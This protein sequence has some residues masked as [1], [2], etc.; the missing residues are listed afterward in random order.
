M[1]AAREERDALKW[2]GGNPIVAHP[3]CRLFS[4]LS[5]FSTAPESE[6]QLAYWSVGKVR[7]WGGVLE[8]PAHSRLWKDVKLPI[9][10]S[11]DEWGFTLAVP[12]FWFGHSAEKDTWLYICGCERKSLPEIP[13]RMG[14]PSD[15]F[16]GGL[17]S[18]GDRRKYVPGSRH[19]G[20]RSATPP[21]FARWLI[22][23]AERCKSTEF[24]SLTGTSHLFHAGAK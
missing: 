19:S 15:L 24:S 8:H 11:K 13:M 6:K 5:H 17:K 10:G 22:Q 16:A 4:R 14:F 1:F 23:T 18:S 7:E 21:D 2:P 12:Q 3:P 20:I 9:P